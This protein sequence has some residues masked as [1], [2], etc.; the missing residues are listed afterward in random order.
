VNDAQLLALP[1]SPTW[2]ALRAWAADLRDHA[3]T[4][5]EQRRSARTLCAILDSCHDLRQ[6]HPQLSEQLWQSALALA[7]KIAEPDGRK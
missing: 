3:L 2:A 6:R 4:L 7:N 5:E 1:P